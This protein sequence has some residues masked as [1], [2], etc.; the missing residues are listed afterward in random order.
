[1]TAGDS[2][3]LSLQTGEVLRARDR[4]CGWNRPDTGGGRWKP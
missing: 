1:V 2:H 4:A 3:V